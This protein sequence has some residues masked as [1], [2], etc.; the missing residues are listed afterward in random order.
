MKTFFTSI[1]NT[2]TWKNTN[3]Q[4][5]ELNKIIKKKISRYYSLLSLKYWPV[6]NGYFP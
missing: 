2:N 4:K 6:I 5:S 3:S 1:R